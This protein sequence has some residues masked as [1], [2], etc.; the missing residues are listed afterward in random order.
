MLR[1]YIILL[2]ISTLRI[3]DSKAQSTVDSYFLEMERF[4]IKHSELIS[5]RYIY[6]NGSEKIIDITGSQIPLNEVKVTY[7]LYNNSKHLVDFSC[8]EEGVSCIKSEEEKTSISI[9]IPFDTK[10]SCYDF[11]NMISELKKRLN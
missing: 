6:L 3:S 4:F 2:F 8:K 1:T 10:K 5:E 9:G 7:R 11:I